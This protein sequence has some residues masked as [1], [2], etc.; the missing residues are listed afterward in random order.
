[1]PL[2]DRGPL[3]VMFV[4]TNMPVGGAETLLTELIRRMDR[5][6]FAP[7]FC[8]LKHFDRL[9]E[10]LSREVPAFTGLLSRK[11]DVMVLWRLMRL[12]RRRR[13][14]AVVTIG[15]GDKMFWGRLAAWLSGVPVICSAL[16]STGLP[17][18]VEF[19]NRLLAPLTDAFIAVAEPHGRYLTEHE[20]CPARKVRVIF[21]GI[22]AERFHPRPPNRRLQE[23]LNLDPTAPVAGIV[24][25]LRP[26]KNHEMF[27]QV[28]ALV[29]RELPAA[30]FLIVGD[31]PERTKLESLARSLGVAEAV[32]F[33]GTRSD[34]DEVL[35]LVDVLLLTSHMEANPICLLEAMASEKPVVAT[36]VGSVTETVLPDRTGYLVSPGDSQGMAARVLELFR[37]RDRAAS[38]GR[39]GREQVIARWTVDRMVRGYEDLIAELYAVK[40]G[41]K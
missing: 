27:L 14:D 6:R 26:E 2:A 39:A 18:Y 35:P 1:M 32:R 8:C 19:P 38:M 41:A 40:S 31:G 20:G 24:A 28:A 17:D 36:R 9:G 25:A 13:I 16:H 11:Y 34:V 5:E 7:E 37:D 29:H 22:D 30:R 33:L 4:L 15:A 10:V 12:L 3:R 21:N 23:E